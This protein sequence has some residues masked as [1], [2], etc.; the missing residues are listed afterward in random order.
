MT[1][2]WAPEWTP[3]GAVEL[4]EPW[5]CK[6]HPQRSLVRSVQFSPDES[7]VRF[8]R[9]LLGE[10]RLEVA[11]WLVG[12]SCL[13]SPCRCATSAAGALE[14]R[15][16]LPCV[17]APGPHAMPRYRQH[18][19]AA[20]CACPSCHQYLASEFHAAEAA[21]I[22]SDHCSKVP[23]LICL[24]CR[25]SLP[26]ISGGRRSRDAFRGP[27]WGMSVGHQE[28]PY[29]TVGPNRD[30]SNHTPGNGQQIACSG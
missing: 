30:R 28:T 9:F 25:L 5:I 18:R 27:Q 22:P 17:R 4:F 12:S 8:S 11:G 19:P 3:E 23:S 6:L 24:S 26:S 10:G 14:H 15:R 21:D 1:S 13:R 2:G 29:E 16:E 7:V 20:T